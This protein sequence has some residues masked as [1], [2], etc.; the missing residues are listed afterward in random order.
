M[1]CEQ[2]G[3]EPE[4][5]NMPVDPSDLSYN[6]QQAIVLFQ[7]L[8]DKIEGMAGMWLGKDYSGLFDIMR[9][10]DIFDKKRVF[11]LL[12]ICISEAHKHYEQ[13]SKMR[14]TLS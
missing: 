8:P 13:Q 14:E 9:L 12:Q 6:C 4:E 1:M 5:E 7:I 10:L 11:E 3:Y 2:M